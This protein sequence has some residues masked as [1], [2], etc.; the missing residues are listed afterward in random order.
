M[1]QETIFKIGGKDYVFCL[2]IGAF[3]P[4]EREIGKSLL[5]LLNP[6]EGKFTEAMTVENMKTILKYGLKDV[7]K[8]DDTIYELME[9]FIAD[10][11]TLDTLAGKVLEAV[12]LKSDFFIPK[13]QSQKVEKA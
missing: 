11:N 7:K 10:G 8:D 13:A 1:R 3:V 2:T 9:Q 4:I 12:L 5:A 6:A